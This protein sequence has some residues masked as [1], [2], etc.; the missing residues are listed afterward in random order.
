MG[1]MERESKLLNVNNG[2]ERE[3]VASSQGRRRDLL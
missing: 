3:G 2:G 1:G